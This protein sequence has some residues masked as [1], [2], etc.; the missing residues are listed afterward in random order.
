M[1]DNNNLD[2]QFVANDYKS[3]RHIPITVFTVASVHVTLFLGI[4]LAG[5]CKKT[6]E[7]QRSPG[8]QMAWSELI[9]K[10][11]A[12]EKAIATEAPVEDSEN[13]SVRT[14]GFQPGSEGGER[15]VM[16]VG[17]GGPGSKLTPTQPDPDPVPTPRAN[18]AS[19]GAKSM[20][21]PPAPRS[22]AVH[23]VQ[24]GDSLFKIAK[25]Y[26]TTPDALKRSNGLKSDVI[27]PG[28]KLNIP[29]AVKS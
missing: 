7:A 2:S 24:K 15:S 1:Q 16:T 27:H 10:A 14:L 6:A 12:S 11:K 3:R 22:G 4:L 9:E 19:P 25:H 28:Q 29:G 26:G 17:V 23:T 18:A 8:E 13:A 20:T 5:G 21:P